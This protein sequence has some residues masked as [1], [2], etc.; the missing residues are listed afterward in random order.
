MLFLCGWIGVEDWCSCLLD[1]VPSDFG[2]ASLLLCPVVASD[3][4]VCYES[5]AGMFV[6]FR[7]GFLGVLMTFGCLRMV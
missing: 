2:S 3:E 5:L 7:F 4:F 1:H 6:Q